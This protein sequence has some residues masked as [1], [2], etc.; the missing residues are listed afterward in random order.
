MSLRPSFKLSLPVATLALLI[1]FAA[2]PGGL[3]QPA[4]AN[5]SSVNA[6]GDVDDVGGDPL[7]DGRQLVHLRPLEGDLHRRLAAAS[8]EAG[9][10]HRGLD[11]R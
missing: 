2:W 5:V 8:D 3:S 10:L 1:A 7:G 11:T 4:E 6:A 9:L